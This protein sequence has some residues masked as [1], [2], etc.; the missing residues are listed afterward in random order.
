MPEM[1]K[2]SWNT[3]DVNPELKH[4]VY[5]SVEKAAADMVG[6]TSQMKQHK[7]DL[8]ML[9]S[10]GGWAREAFTDAARR[11]AESRA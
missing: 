1:Q 2:E 10:V 7:P 6:S 4:T 9:P 5:V 8:K 11:T 3:V